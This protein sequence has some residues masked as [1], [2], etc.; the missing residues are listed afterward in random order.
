MND[1][2][3]ALQGLAERV[4]V[5]NVTLVNFNTGRKGNVGGLANKNA[6]GM[7][8]TRERLNKMLS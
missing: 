6:Y 2:F 5:Q 1:G 3:G 8:L 4:D 7:N